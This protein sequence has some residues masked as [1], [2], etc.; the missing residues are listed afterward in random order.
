M[1]LVLLQ[2]VE[3]VGLEIAEVDVAQTVALGERS[4]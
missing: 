1:S 3:L 2:I 4:K